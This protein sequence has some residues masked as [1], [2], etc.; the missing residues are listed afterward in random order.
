MVRQRSEEKGPQPL[1]VQRSGG[2]GW[3]SEFR[4]EHSRRK[5]KWEGR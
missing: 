2:R 5:V 4:K 3:G 1:N